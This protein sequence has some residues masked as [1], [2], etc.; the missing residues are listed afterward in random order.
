MEFIIISTYSLTYCRSLAYK[1]SLMF[2]YRK[3]KSFEVSLY[4]ANFILFVVFLY[5][6]Y[7][8]V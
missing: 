3:K 2:A 5:T 8:L 7:T 1:T 4:E 6:I